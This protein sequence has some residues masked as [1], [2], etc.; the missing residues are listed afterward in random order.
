M[1]I[2]ILLAY[3]SVCIAVFAMIGIPL[4]RISAPIASVG[5]L[6]LVFALVQVL[7]FYHPYTDTSGQYM[8]AKKIPYS[9]E[10]ATQAE[11]LTVVEPSLVAWFDQQSRA[12]LERGGEVEVAFDSI[13][14]RVF[15]GRVRDLLP[16][17]E[18]Y[19]EQDDFRWP[20]AAEAMRIP[21]LIEITDPGF[22]IYQPQLVGGSHAKTVV[23]DSHARELALV[24]KT[25]LRMSAWLN[26]VTPVT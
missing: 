18:E 13:P 16:M 15:S 26:Y 9:A 2:L 12:R 19:R 7:N 21:V 14:G 6:L 10:G 8:V 25:L 24:R 5:G 3:V 4:N 23:Y 20:P 17:A 22:D 11:P 1:E